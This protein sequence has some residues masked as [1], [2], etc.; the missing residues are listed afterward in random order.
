[1]PNAHKKAHV[2]VV[3]DRFD[4]GYDNPAV[5]V[6]GIDR[7]IGSAEKLVQVYSRANR[8][9]NGMPTPV[10]LD[11][12]NPSKHVEEAIFQFA[13]PRTCASSSGAERLLQL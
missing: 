3:C 2:L 11:F 4:I 7:K 10:V 5:K 13:L 9:V 12:Q 6:M 8:L 1:M